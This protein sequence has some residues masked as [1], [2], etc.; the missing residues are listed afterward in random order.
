[1]LLKK[2]LHHSFTGHNRLVT[3]PPQSGFNIISGRLEFCQQSG[4]ETASCVTQLV[5]PQPPAPA[6]CTFPLPINCHFQLHS[7]GNDQTFKVDT[8]SP[9]LSLLNNLS[10]SLSPVIRPGGDRS[11]FSVQ[12]LEAWGFRPG[13][14]TEVF[15]G[16]PQHAPTCPP[17]E[18]D[19]NRR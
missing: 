13:W 15:L 11:V 8:G 14:P 5:S 9:F 16:P 7:H 6:F 10:L 19:F 1:M 12:Q 17:H 18:T 2:K 4:G 3:R